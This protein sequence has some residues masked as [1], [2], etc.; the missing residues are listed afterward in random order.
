MSSTVPGRTP[1]MRD[2]AAHAAVSPMTVSRTLRG[3]P[4]VSPEMRERVL[5]AVEA[6]RYRRNDLA[7]GLRTGRSSGLLGLVIT[8]LS[9][10]FYSELAL[11]VESI[12]SAAGMRVVIGNTGGDLERERLLVDDMASRR[13]D[14]I[15][16][17]PAGHDHSHL[18]PD[19]L[20]GLPVVLATRP[21]S[22]LDVDCVVVDDFGGSR[23]ATAALV[24]QGH[25]R[26]GFL[27]LGRSVWTGA[28]RLRGHCAA[29]EEAGL[30]VDDALLRS[31]P[32]D[33]GAAEAVALEL[34]SRDDPPT[35]L[36][37]ANNRNTVGAYRAIAETGSAAALAGFDDVPLAD[38][39]AAPIDV[40]TYDTG[41]VGRRAA[42]LLLERI[43]GE[44]PPAHPR[45]VTIGTTLK[46]YRPLGAPHP[47]GG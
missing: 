15:I 47:S 19:A 23:R 32:A 1:T 40:V 9:N 11:G 42:E 24:A 34:L 31:V 4:R 46:R 29:L 7:R 44:E 37:A 14:G 5:A 28:E 38:L 33:P 10:P 20:H 26:I 30:P 39:F 12:A 21:P 43:E 41:E 13:V 18:D 2:V 45:L 35:A 17:V 8:N 3:D 16:V 36:F 25:R 22:G 27:G 6:L